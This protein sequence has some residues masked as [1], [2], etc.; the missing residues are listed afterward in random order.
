MASA[1]GNE[2]YVCV[3]VC[4]CVCVMGACECVGP[5]MPMAENASNGLRVGGERHCVVCYAGLER[6]WS[7]LPLTL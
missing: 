2:G 6:G 7:W 3:C 1:R 4:V 5:R